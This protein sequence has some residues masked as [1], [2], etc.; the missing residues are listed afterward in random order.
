VV[1][2]AAAAAVTA[3]T[4]DGTIAVE[5]C[6]TCRM[7]AFLFMCYTNQQTIIR[8][9]FLHHSWV[10]RGRTRDGVGVPLRRGEHSHHRDIHE[11][12]FVVVSVIGLGA[13][14]SV[15]QS[16][17]INDQFLAE[18]TAKL[19]LQPDAIAATSIPKAELE[20]HLIAA[21]CYFEKVSLVKVLTLSS[22]DCCEPRAQSA[23]RLSTTFNSVLAVVK[24]NYEI[25]P[26]VVNKIVTYNFHICD[27]TMAVII[28]LHPKYLQGRRNGAARSPELLCKPY[29]TLQ[30]IEKPAKNH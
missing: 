5:Q 10:R 11:A 18:I 4:Y 12:K 17:D 25:P 24:S 9:H 30:T 20:Q 2:A 14:V 13:Y 15:K 3:T 19:Q 23:T 8:F 27:S 28:M 21:A 26:T 1:I 6:N 16:K 29:R 7:M 22:I